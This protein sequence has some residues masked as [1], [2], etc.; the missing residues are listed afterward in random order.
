MFST[1]KSACFAH[2]TTFATGKSSVARSGEK[3]VAVLFSGLFDEHW[4]CC[5]QTGHELALAL[6]VV[7]DRCM[8]LYGVGACTVDDFASIS[9]NS[10]DTARRT[11]IAE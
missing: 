4:S 7:R 2:Q 10:P 1:E 9:E 3:H 11:T 8:L 5:R 6:D